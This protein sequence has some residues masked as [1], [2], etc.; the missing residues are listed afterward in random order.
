MPISTYASPTSPVLPARIRDACYAQ[1]YGNPSPR[2]LSS[3]TCSL[4]SVPA[5]T[6][7]R[8]VPPRCTRILPPAP[9]PPDPS[10]PD[11]LRSY[12]L[13]IRSDICKA[14]GRGRWMPKPELISCL[15]EVRSW[16][17]G[18]L[19]HRTRGGR[20]RR[21]CESGHQGW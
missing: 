7:T 16:A 18:A 14:T 13:R 3:P 20:G 12:P 19:R 9:P 15:H 5:P 21:A 4:M 2:S 6:R 10:L 1:I 8:P 17:Q 11:D